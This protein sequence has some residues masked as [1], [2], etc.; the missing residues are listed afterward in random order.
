MHVGHESL[1]EKAASMNDRVIIAVCGSDYDRGKDFIPFRDRIKLIT[2]IF[3]ENNIT[4]VS[5]DDAKLKLDGTFT[6]ENWHIWSDELFKNARICPYD[7][8]NEIT[9]YTGELSYATKL[10]ELYDSH[11]FFIASRRINDISGTEIRKNWKVHGDKINRDFYDYLRGR[12]ILDL[13]GDITLK[14]V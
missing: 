6:L 2:I 7:C 14:G 5:I 1:I 11:N 13:L 3:S 4:V 8:G 10:K 12:F 9:W